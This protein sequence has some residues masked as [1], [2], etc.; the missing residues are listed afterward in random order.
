MT[1][2]ADDHLKAISASASTYYYD[3]EGR[4]VRATS[5][6]LD[7]RFVVG[8]TAGSDLEIIHMITGADDSVKAVYIYAEGR[9]VMRFGVDSNGDI[10]PVTVRFYLE[11]ASGSV[12][13][14]A[15][16]DGTLG[17]RFR[18]DGFGIAGTEAGLSAPTVEVADGTGGDFRFHGACLEAHTG[19]YHMRARDYDPETGSFLECDP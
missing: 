7:R 8:P 17:P 11:D 10:N 14:L 18:Y 9:P 3:P 13:G 16:N 15:R 19:F 4:R 1:Y 2:T 12:L 5:M 6:G